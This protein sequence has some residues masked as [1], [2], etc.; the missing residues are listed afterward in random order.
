MYL[1][2]DN[3]RVN[4]LIV[5][6][7]CFGIDWL[8]NR[9]NDL[10]GAQICTLNEL[11]THRHQGANRRWSSVKL[12]YYTYHKRPKRPASGQVGTPSNIMVVAPFKS[13]P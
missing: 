7:P 4:F 2:L 6:V 5:P 12:V 10:R 3:F 1:R 13:G 11:V 8:T 9:S